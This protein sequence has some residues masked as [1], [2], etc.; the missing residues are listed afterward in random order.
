M[1]V[2][3]LQILLLWKRGTVQNLSHSN[4]PAQIHSFIQ[5]VFDT[6]SAASLWL[7]RR[8][9]ATAMILTVP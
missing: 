5:S 3:M 4:K 2:V 9:S 1:A 7:W 8:I 6:H